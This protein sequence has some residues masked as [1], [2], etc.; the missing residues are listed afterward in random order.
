M[1]PIHSVYAQVDF[2]NSEGAPL[3]NLEFLKGVYEAGELLVFLDRK[4]TASRVN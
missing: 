3:S 2:H 1:E 4:Q